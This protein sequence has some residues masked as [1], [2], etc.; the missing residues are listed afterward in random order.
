M[1]LLNVIVAAVVG[2]AFGGLWYNA[3]AKPWIAASGVAVGEDGKPKNSASPLPYIAGFVATLLVAG[4]MR[5]V[6]ALSG[7]DTVGE[8][9]VSGFGIGLFLAVPWLIMNYSFAGRP[10]SLMLIDGGHATI[11]CTV[12]G[13]VLILF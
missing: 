7:I 6:F 8:G 3:L 1:E 9:A 11:G 5:H 12:I 2:F 13:T 4:M 10:V